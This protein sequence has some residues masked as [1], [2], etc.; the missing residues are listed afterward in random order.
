MNKK[1]LLCKVSII[2]DGDDDDEVTGIIQCTKF[3]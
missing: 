2:I 3:V 1:A